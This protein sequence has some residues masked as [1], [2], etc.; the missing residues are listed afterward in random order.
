MS[1][2]QHNWNYSPI[3]SLETYYCN[4]YTC[5]RVKRINPD[6]SASFSDSKPD[7]MQAEHRHHLRQWAKKS[8]P[9]ELGRMI[10]SNHPELG[11][12]SWQQLVEEI[13][14]IVRLERGQ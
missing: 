4:V 11:E 7:L 14:D 10:A 5:N 13:A 1:K 9:E 3:G 6:G 8:K 2:H 12:P